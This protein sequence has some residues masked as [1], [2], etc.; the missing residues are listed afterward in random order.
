MA[1]DGC[2]KRANA[3]A[4]ACLSPVAAYRDDILLLTIALYKH[5]AVIDGIIVILIDKDKRLKRGSYRIPTNRAS[6]LYPSREMLR[7][8]TGLI[9]YATTQGQ[10]ISRSL[11]LSA[12]VQLL[13]K[14]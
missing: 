9:I 2:E 3:S 7:G 1:V 13:H 11:P 14:R 10:D 8:F 4:P 5:V 12:V 6:I